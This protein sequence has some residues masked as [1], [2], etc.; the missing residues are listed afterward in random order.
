MQLQ[1]GHKLLF[2]EKNVCTALKWKV[3]ETKEQRKS[4]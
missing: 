4:G 2:E 1:K 3:F